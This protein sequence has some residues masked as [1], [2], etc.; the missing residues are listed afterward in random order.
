[1]HDIDFFIN[2]VIKAVELKARQSLQALHFK[3]KVFFAPILV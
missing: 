2:D 3:S 1:M